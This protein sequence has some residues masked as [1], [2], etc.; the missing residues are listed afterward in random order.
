MGELTIRRNQNIAVPWYQTVEKTE[1]QTGTAQK[2]IHTKAF[3]ISETLQQQISRTTEAQI[4]ESRRTLQTGEIV[5]AEVKEDLSQMAKLAEKAAGGSDTDRAALQQQLDQ[6]KD[7]IVRV[8]RSAVSGD[9]PLFLDEDGVSDASDA[10]LQAA[11][12]G[13][14]SSVHELP[15]WIAKGLSDGTYTTQQ[16]LAALGLDA[17][18][19]T[20]EILASLAKNPLNNSAASR[21]LATLY[22]G[23]VINGLASSGAVRPE[24][25]LNGLK[26]LLEKV[27]QGASPD[28]ALA[29]L[30][31]GAFTSFEDFESQFLDGTAQGLKDFLAYLL[32]DVSFP[33]LDLASLLEGLGGMDLLD[34]MSILDPSSNP[35]EAVP[36]QDGAANPAGA[37]GT[38]DMP[39]MA[40]LS[41]TEADAASV[42]TSVVQFGEVQVA[43]KDLSGVTFHAAANELVIS[44]SADVIIRGGGENSPAIVL[45]GS[46]TVTLQDVH[47]PQL[48]VQTDSAQVFY[49]GENQVE[50]VVMQPNTVLTLNGSGAVKVSAFH[51]NASNTLRLNGGAVIVGDGRTLGTLMLPVVLDGPVS[52]AAQAANVQDSAGRA[53]E[54]FDIIW[55]TLLPGWNAMTGMETEGQQ[56][57]MLLQQPEFARLWLAKEDPSHGS[58][59]HTLFLQG[60][61][62]AGRSKTRYAY[63]H[64]N[65]QGRTFEEIPM[66]PNPFTITGGTAGK[67][68]FY[69]EESHTLCILSDQ[70][71]AISGG[72]GTDA[73]REPFSGRV[74]LADGIGEIE[75]VLE[76]VVCQVAEGC[77]FHLGRAN[78]VTLLLQNGTES[79]FESGEGCA[80]ISLGDGATLRIDRVNTKDGGRTPIGA[81]AAIGGEGGAGIGRSSGESSDRTSEIVI[82]GGRVKASG[83]GGGAGI[84]AGKHG[85]IGAVTIL[86]GTVDAEGGTGGGAGIGGALGA[87]AG[88]ISIRG[89]KITAAAVYHA[90]AIGAG[91]RGACGDIL[92]TG[93]A[94]IVKAIGGNPGADIGA[95]LFGGCGKVV[96]SG[97][98]DIG[99]ARL[100]TQGGVPLQTGKD[101][102]ITLPQFRLSP[103]ALLL[104]GM[105]IRTRERA[106][107]ARRS[108][109]ADLRWVNRIQAAYDAMNGQVKRRSRGARNVPTFIHGAEDPVR[110]AET[111]GTLLEDAREAIPRQSAQVLRPQSGKG[112]DAVRQLLG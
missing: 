93:T 5:L 107:E 73:I 74:A 70:V 27:A 100:K 43:G 9:V 59:I 56:S 106:L 23:S 15:D 65:R 13:D 64:W 54:P 30:T 86:G 28:E 66:Y 71:S 104:E 75:L 51:A 63:L 69:E 55:K 41:G 18:A 8:L 1:K 47:T 82:C 90:A 76:G 38:A 53:L 99:K 50:E 7:E 97:A 110:D 21:C 22:L 57:R 87:S 46:G 40:S 81:L 67:D 95:C 105:D 84:G 78:A 14:A 16:V 12:G 98:A 36:L 101:T 31:N 58:P 17:S 42:G 79:R 62:E 94:R 33:T 60:K 4:R 108:L 52:L 32:A 44:G 88:D 102:T 48:N 89:G 103:S 25:A 112:A 34:M 11:L 3:T 6:L 92:I 111:A 29:E 49:T 72:S 109:E 10:L 96:L 20:S 37:A 91:V 77:A 85:A 83:S 26:A 80:G 19:E 45:N 35:P 68:W 61:D 24:D 39:A 2:T